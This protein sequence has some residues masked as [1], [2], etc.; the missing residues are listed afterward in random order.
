MS[1]KEVYVERFDLKKLHMVEFKEQFQLE[2]SNSF[3]VLEN[4]HASED[5][6]VGWENSSQNIKTTD[7][8]SLSQYG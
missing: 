7:I 4:L 6:N 5:M 2:L 1:S 3:A 8:D